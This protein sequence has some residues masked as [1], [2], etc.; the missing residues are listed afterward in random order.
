MKF[1]TYC[2]LT[3]MAGL[4]IVLTL[5]SCTKLDEKPYDIIIS[6]NFLQ[7]REDVIRDFL[8]SFEHGYWSIGSTFVAQENSADQLITPNREGDWYDGGIYQRAHYHTWIPTDSY[9]SDMWNALYQGIDLATNSLED[10]QAIDPAKFNMTEAEKADFLAELRVHRAWFYLRLLD[11]YRNI[12]II[13]K[14]KGEN[15]GTTQSTPEESF[16]FIEKELKESIDGLPTKESLGENAVGRW[17]KGAAMSLL[18]RL[19]LNAKVYIGQDKFSECAAVC[20]DIIDGKYGNYAIEDRWDAPFDYNNANSSETVF[21]FP[22]SQ[23]YTHWHYT[24]DMYWRFYEANTFK[25]FDFTE[26]G[27]N[28]P[29]WSLAPGR[30]VDG[31]ELPQALGKPFLKFS[32]YPDDVR[33]KKYKNLGNSQREGMFLFGYLPYTED[34][35][36]KNVQTTK[37]YT[38]YMRDAVGMFTNLPPD[39]VPA[40]KE[41]NM[42]HADHNSGFR[43]VKYPIYPSDDK[44]AIMSAYAEIRLAEIYYSLAECKYRAGDKPGAAALLNSVRKRYYPSGSASLYKTDGSDLND[45]EVIDEWGREFIGEGRRRTDL[46]RWGVFNAGN[47]WDKQPDAGNYTLI[48]PI[49][50]RVLNINPQ[51]NQNPGY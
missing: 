47:W 9:T 50:R 13:T 26:F 14:V 48:F 45:Q 38:L 40:D 8:R 6:S 39:E 2:A 29:K 28:N 25:Y 31:N 44:N 24:D 23:G 43:L 20:Q 32:K 19:Y 5:N 17:T 34:G 33:L 7:T 30:N 27:A 12:E 51:L 4:A 21:A 11:L 18:A 16:S 42:D 41:S 49:G 1:K 46:I 36:V 10:I 3:L 37:G 22:S 15:T 35:V